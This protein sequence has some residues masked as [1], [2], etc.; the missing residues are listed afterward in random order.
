MIKYPN[1]SFIVKPFQYPCSIEIG[2]F[3]SIATELQIVDVKHPSLVYEKV[4]SNYA[5]NEDFGIPNYYKNVS[6]NKLIVENDVLIGAYCT[7]TTG[8]TIGNGAIIKCESRV[9]VDVPPYAVMKDNTISRYRFPRN[10]RE[11]LLQL[12]WWDWSDQEIKNRIEELKDYER[13]T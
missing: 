10:I 5:F 3:S 8:I 13:L 4:V 6:M 12:K 9:S 11:K 7:I 1:H 2:K